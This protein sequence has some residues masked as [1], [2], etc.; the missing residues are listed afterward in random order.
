MPAS[1]PSSRPSRPC[2]SGVSSAT[3]LWA[4]GAALA[5]PGHSSRQVL[6]IRECK[7]RRIRE[8]QE[9]FTVRGCAE[10]GL[11]RTRQSRCSACLRHAL[12]LVRALAVSD[13]RSRSPSALCPRFPD[14]PILLLDLPR[15]PSYHGD[16]WRARSAHRI[17]SPLTPP[18]RERA[19]VFLVAQQEVVA[20]KRLIAA[21]VL[22]VVALSF[23]APALACGG[24]V[25]FVGWG[26]TLSSIG[27]WYGVSP[28]AI[29]RAN[30]SSTPTTSST[31]SG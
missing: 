12:F 10:E 23:A 19:R 22:A 7:N 9:R 13:S 31:G 27:R 18:H 21:I 17:L 14:S 20:W 30:G 5:H 11:I 15:I 6:R 28:W 2:S 25:H 4:S 26:E 1:R 16:R 8:W 24:T 3:P 29:A